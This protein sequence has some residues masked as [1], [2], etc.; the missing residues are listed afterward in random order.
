VK[1]LKQ[2]S[3]TNLYFLKLFLA[4]PDVEA[5]KDR[6]SPAPYTQTNTEI[7]HINTSKH[8]DTYTHTCMVHQPLC[9]Y[10]YVCIHTF[11]LHL[12]T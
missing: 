6:T 11:V 12:D 10:N 7:D 8:T 2:F 3:K 9:L 4:S 1:V 5:S